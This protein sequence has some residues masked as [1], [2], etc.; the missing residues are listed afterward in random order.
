[1]WKA[2]SMIESSL[3]TDI[4]QNLCFSQQ[5]R[6]IVACL[7]REIYTVRGVLLKSLKNIS[8]LLDV[9]IYD[10]MFLRKINIPMI[11]IILVYYSWFY[12]VQFEIFNSNNYSSMIFVESLLFT[13]NQGNM[14][15]AAESS[16]QGD[17]YKEFLIQI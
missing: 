2:P 3:T 14:I 5:K 6:R 16:L 11:R 13:G 7:F 17:W 1:M 12:I 8:V 10:N 4:K 9:V 15:T